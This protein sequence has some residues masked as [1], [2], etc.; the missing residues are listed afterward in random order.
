MSDQQEGHRTTSQLV[1]EY[2]RNVI[3]SVK[4]AVELHQNELSTLEQMNALAFKKHAAI[5]EK[6]ETTENKN[7]PDEQLKEYLA[8]L[9]EAEKAIAEL[10]TTL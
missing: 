4:S 6:L 10:D 9:E 8:E 2:V 5:L 1:E 7:E 3:F